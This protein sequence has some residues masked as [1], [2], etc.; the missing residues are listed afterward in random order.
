MIETAGHT[1]PNGLRIVHH[2]K[3]G[4]KT[5]VIDTIFDV[6][7]RLESPHHTGLAHLF[8]H[9]MFGG[10]LHVPH[11]DAAIEAAGGS[12]N[13]WT[14]Q[15]FTNYYTTVPLE[16][17]ETALWAESDR[18]LHLDIS[19][20]AIEIQRQ[21]VCEEF[22]QTCLNRPYG[23][24]S[25]H[26]L[27]L[28]YT[29]HPYR[30]PVIGAK[31]SHIQ[32]IT[33]TQI[34]DFHSHFYTPSRAV[35]AIVADIP[36]TRAFDLTEK[37]YADIPSVPYKKI[38]LPQE[39]EITTP[40]H[41]QV[42]GPVP[43]TRITLAFHI[44]GPSHPLFPAADIITDIL[45]S[46]HASRLKRLLISSHIFSAIDASVSATEDIGY[47]MVTATLHSPAYTSQAIDTLRRT[48]DGLIHRPVPPHEMQR[49]INRFI[50]NRHISLL[51]P[52]K[53]AAAMARAAITGR[54][55]NSPIPAYRAL[56]PEKIQAAAQTI[57]NPSRQITFIYNPSR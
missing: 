55:I 27:P 10:S 47:L 49:V 24:T 56:G 17:I 51:S 7:S 23:D 8:E 2:R 16:N 26:L 32:E 19:P 33:P 6:G 42:S 13:A 34:S 41:L 15:D 57:L 12:D 38:H 18:M 9:L 46:G 40:R 52:Q 35:I 4:I 21:V 29:T 22:R 31:I 30:W 3:P 39:P 5:A 50:T 25:H 53:L 14:S 43:L 44:P 20:R 45:A 37:W 11:F 48:L 36:H 28:I 54:D 1:L